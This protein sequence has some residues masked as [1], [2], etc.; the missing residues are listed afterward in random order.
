MKVDLF[1]WA[2]VRSGA[3]IVT[4]VARCSCGGRLERVQA[5]VDET[6]RIPCN[7]DCPKQAEVVELPKR[8]KGRR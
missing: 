6:V 7:D 3:A 1:P 4:T 5:R 8:G 2:R